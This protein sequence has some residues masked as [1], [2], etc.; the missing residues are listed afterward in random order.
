MAHESGEAGWSD[1]LELCSKI[2][3]AE[4]FNSFFALFL[5]FEERET[6]ASRYLII[7]ALLEGQLTQREIAETYRVSIAQITRGS[8][9]LKIIDPKF[10]KF[11][12][13]AL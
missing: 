10:E 2:K 9:A 7:K 1:F 8:N 11:L 12:K 4:A 13:R 3:S 6:M 5:T